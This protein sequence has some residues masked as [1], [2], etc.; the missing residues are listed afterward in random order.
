MSNA[1]SL[2]LT[3]LAEKLLARKREA[4]VEVTERFLTRHPD[5]LAKY[6]ERARIFGIEDAGFHT[7][8]LA[9]ALE[10]GD[11]EAFADYA[12]WT[13]RML[14]ARGI[15]PHFLVENLE[16]LAQVLAVELSPDE[17][18]WMRPYVERGLAACGEPVAVPG[19]ADEP[20]GLALTCR[21]YTQAILNGQRRAALSVVQEALREGHPVTA[22]YVEVLQEALYEVGRRW[23]GNRIAVAQEHMATVITQYV[24]SQLYPQLPS[25][26]VSRGRAVVTGVQ[27]ENHQVGANMV[28]DLLEADG[29]DV[30]FL[31]TN[32]PHQGIL[33]V[34]EEH[35]ADLLGISTTMLFNAG[36][37]R[38]LIHDIQQ[39][40]GASRPHILV[41]GAP[42]RLSP[43]LWQEVGA[44]GF[45]PDAGAAVVLA[46]GF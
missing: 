43:H 2:L 14:G 45:A 34:V 21:L 3:R 29:W 16:D 1:S 46:R 41:G 4:A 35:Q 5:W 40:M 28:A 13:T 10:A 9:G 27:G 22:L 8:F 19:F 23:E 7:E 39:R 25:P 18:A 6:G 26:S 36:R 12:R 20:Q 38:Q 44:E 33:Q 11:P 32:M 30:R 37:V 42:F 17:T 24:M 31:G 15:G